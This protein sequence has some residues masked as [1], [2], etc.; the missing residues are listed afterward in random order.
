MGG[1]GYKASLPTGTDLGKWAVREAGELLASHAPALETPTTPA[2]G[3]ELRRLRLTTALTLGVDRGQD[4]GPLH[5]G[6]LCHDHL[7]VSDGEQQVG[8]GQVKQVSETRRSTRTPPRRRSPGQKYPTRMFSIVFPSPKPN[9][10]AEAV[11]EAIQK[12]ISK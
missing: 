4:L 7:Q 12:T 2:A 11:R 6:G 10:M 1:S 3:Q 5:P 8:E 9:H